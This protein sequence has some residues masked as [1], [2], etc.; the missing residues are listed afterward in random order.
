MNESTL[1]GS[2]FV[3]VLGVLIAAEFA[4]PRRARHQPRQAR[5]QTNVLMLAAASLLVRAISFGA[6]LILA[7]SAAVYAR[8]HEFG[9]FNLTGWPQWIE[10]L[11]AIVL[12]DLAV[13]GQHLI[14]HKVP[15]LWRLH[16]VHHTDRDLDVTSALRFHPGE[17][18]LSAFYKAGIVLLLGPSLLAVFLFEVFLNAC[19]MFNHSNIRLPSAL[20][21]SLRQIIVTPDMHR[22]HHSVER[23]EHMSN[24]GFCLSVWDRVFNT[25]CA[26]PAAGHDDMIIG[27]P[28]HQA[29]HT[30]ALRWSLLLPFRRSKP[31]PKRTNP[32][33]VSTEGS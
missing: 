5:W 4:A 10:I 16:S 13:W 29:D 20:D 31:H 3:L 25:Y 33:T 22:V 6:P 28:E 9:I 27:L 12:L 15:L 14:S 8:T 23:K 17:I 19:A 24:F 26:Q 1:R 32:P 18:L 2:I 21:Q 11:L 30:A 7:A